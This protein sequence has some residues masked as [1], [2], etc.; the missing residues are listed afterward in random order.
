MDLRTRCVV[1]LS[2]LGTLWLA[3]GTQREHKVLSDVKTGRVAGLEVAYAE[4]DH[5]PKKL[6]ELAQ[7]YLDTSQP[8][9]ALGVIDAAP[10]NIR[11][12]PTVDH[13]YARA[14]LDQGRASDALVVERRVLDTCAAIQSKNFARSEVRDPPSGENKDCDPWLLASATRRADILQEL[15][16]LGID[17]A[18]AHPEVSSIAYH[19]ATRQ[20][21]LSVR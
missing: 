14:L 10:E 11:H 8:G 13:V 7:A 20:A 4:S 9:L 3:S 21:T 19:N 18:N 15:V 16:Q 17:D 5:D 6:Q 12:L 2:A 1:V